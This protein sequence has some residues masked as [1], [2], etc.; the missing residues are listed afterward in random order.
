MLLAHMGCHT[1]SGLVA[2][3]NSAK[4]AHAQYILSQSYTITNLA[5]FRVTILIFFF[6]WPQPKSLTIKENNTLI[7]GRSTDNSPIEPICFSY[8]L[9]YVL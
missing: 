6:N 9:S 2:L 8:A 7:N 1:L 4:F 3:C 5:T